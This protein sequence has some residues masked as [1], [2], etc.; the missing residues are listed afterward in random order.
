MPVS[1]S[2]SMGSF[3]TESATPCGWSVCPP[4]AEA[5]VCAESNKFRAEE[6]TTDD[7]GMRTEIFK[8]CFRRLKF[9]PTRECF[10]TLET[11]KCDKYYSAEENAL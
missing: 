4:G 3:S 8:E 9:V 1:T 6:P 10:A 2:E 11:K 5:R 7:Y